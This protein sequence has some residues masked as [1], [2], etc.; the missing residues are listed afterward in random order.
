MRHRSEAWF[1]TLRQPL[2]FGGTDDDV[3][4]VACGSH[5]A[6]QVALS[7]VFFSRHAA[8]TAVVEAEV[9]AAA[10]EEAEAEAAQAQ[11]QAGAEAGSG[12]GTGARLASAA[13]ADQCPSC[14]K[15][16]T[17]W[18]SSREQDRMSHRYLRCTDTSGVHFTIGRPKLSI[19]RPIYR[20]QIYI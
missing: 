12:A 14:W 4:A 3:S 5:Q 9:E 15:T 17:L 6:V 8:T 20:G 11:A 13:A 10:E 16:A 2:R 19:G 18:S 7:S 1:E